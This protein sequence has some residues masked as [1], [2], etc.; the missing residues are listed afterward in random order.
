MAGSTRALAAAPESSPLIYHRIPQTSAGQA[1]CIT[2]TV[3]L[4]ADINTNIMALPTEVADAVVVLEVFA[5]NGV[6]LCLLGSELPNTI[7]TSL[8]ALVDPLNQ[9]A[10]QLGELLTMATDTL[11]NA[12]LQL[13]DAAVA[14]REG[15][16]VI[17]LVPG[18]REGAVVVLV[19]VA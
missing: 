10:Q 9:L 8:Q 13:A 16:D 2:S 17:D 12:R 1:D 11:A 15:R 18:L 6:A 19:K 14:Q 4:L 3:T 7:A 5:A